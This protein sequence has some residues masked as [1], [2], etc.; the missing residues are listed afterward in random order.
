MLAPPPV[1]HPSFYVIDVF[2]RVRCTVLGVFVCFGFAVFACC[3]RLCSGTSQTTPQGSLPRTPPQQVAETTRGLRKTFPSPP[4]GSRSGMPP[5][6]D[7]DL[8]SSCLH[9]NR[10]RIPPRFW[11]HLTDTSL[12]SESPPKA[13]AQDWPRAFGQTPHALFNTSL[14]TPQGNRP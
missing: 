14:R 8:P 1:T 10:P 7:P 5:R 3:S 2:F 11:Q 4:R 13:I 6:C 9:G 12:S